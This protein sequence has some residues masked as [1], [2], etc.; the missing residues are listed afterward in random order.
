VA[1]EQQLHAAAKRHLQVRIEQV[2]GVLFAGLMA[3]NLCTVA[4]RCP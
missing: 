2:F 3:A 4:G 1:A